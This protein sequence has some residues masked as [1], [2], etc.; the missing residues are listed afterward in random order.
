MSVKSSAKK[1]VTK[2]KKDT[3]IELKPAVQKPN[4]LYARLVYFSCQ[5]LASVVL[6]FA[7]L[8]FYQISFAGRIYSGIAVGG[9]SLSGLTPVEAKNLLSNAWNYYSDQGLLLKLNET[10][11]ILTNRVTSTSDPDLAYEL[12]SFNPSKAV[13]SAYSQGRQGNWLMRLIKPVWLSLKAINLPVAGLEIEH[14]KIMQY[15]R[16]SFPGVEQLP[17][18]A[19]LNVDLDGNISFEPEIEGSVIDEQTLQRD[20]VNR[21]QYMNSEPVQIV[22]QPK[23]PLLTQTIVTAFLPQVQQILTDQTIIFR[24]GDKKWFAEPA[25]WYRWL[26]VEY[27]EYSGQ[28]ELSFLSSK[29]DDFFEPI[30]K[31]INRPAQDAKFEIKDGRV[32]AFQASQQGRSLDR[33]AS[34]QAAWTKV[35]EKKFEEVEFIVQTTEPSVTTAEVNELGISEIL[36]I[37]H[38]NFKGSP[39]NRRHNIKVGAAA[40]NGLLIRPGEEFSLLKALLPVDASAGYLPELVI[41]GNRTIPE[42]GG[43]LCQIGTTIFRATLSSGLPVTARR[44]HSYRVVYY[45]PAGTDATIY[46]PAPDYK[47]VNDTGSTVLI[48]TR[49]E[50]D[51]L[52]FEFWG[53][54]DGRQTVQTK[55]RIYNVV[56][57]PPTKIIQT[58]D[59]E[60]GVKK[61]TEKP[62]AGADAEFTYTVTYSNGEVKETIFKSHYIPWQEVCL[63]GVPK[64]TLNPPT[65]DLNNENNSD[66]QKE[67]PSV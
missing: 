48:Q 13:Y 32:T 51:D 27:N 14:E 38:S 26:G 28:A 31:I 37:G 56:Y 58:E 55:P 3:L 15:V 11:V 33:I 9:I 21:W 44:N 41:K 36:G 47:F 19:S 34:L 42:Y 40:L 62:H 24:F 18:P 25:V 50:G 20:I 67:P 2:E 12:V 39:A 4:F 23:H 57:P 7:S 6:I 1:P 10:G 53:K 49:I 54:S 29:A 52:Y 30:E 8:A 22:L 61:C 60:P 17:R 59:L 35:L 63:I 46:D 64:G 16:D 5:V 43:G 66:E 45:E 65:L